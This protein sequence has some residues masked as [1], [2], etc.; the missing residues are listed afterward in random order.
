[1]S[2]IVL[3]ET[4]LVKLV[5]EHVRDLG[6]EPAGANIHVVLDEQSYTLTITVDLK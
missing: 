1:M 4:D 3:K 6:H 2:Q 5:R